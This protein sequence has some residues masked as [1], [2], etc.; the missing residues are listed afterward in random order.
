MSA[1]GIT[2]RL[3][4]LFRKAG[5]AAARADTAAVV[6]DEDLV[7]EQDVHY[8]YRLLLGREPDEEGLRAKRKFVGQPKLRGLV[9]SF[10]ESSEFIASELA[11][12]AKWRLVRKSDVDPSPPRRFFRADR[13]T[14]TDVYFAYR[15]LLQR[16]PDPEGWAGLASQAQR[17]AMPLDTLCKTFLSSPEFRRGSLYQELY[18]L[19][20]AGSP[21]LIELETHR[22][23]VMESDF[24]VGREL[25][26]GRP[27][28]PHIAATLTSFLSPGATFVDVGANIGVFSLM[29]A[30]IVGSGGRVIAIEPNPSNCR[31]IGM[32]AHENGFTNVEIIPGAVGDEPKTL[33]FASLVGSNG[34]VGDPVLTGPP[35]PGASLIRAETLNHLLAREPRVDFIKMD[36][37]GAEH[38]ALLGAREVIARHKPPI[39]LEFTPLGLPTVSGA[40]P[41][42]HL[43]FLGD[44]GYALARIGEGGELSPVTDHA[45]LVTEVVSQDAAQHADLLAYDP[46]SPPEQLR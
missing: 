11:V 29:A 9:E 14:R 31:L 35:G 16:E 38:R 33:V 17:K 24:A 1:P 20:Q 4:R 27:Y 26:D 10:L 32:G 41:E 34:I 15:L 36:I 28:E 2:G 18:G 3:K 25:L 5:P 42:T 46:N 45:A 8:C 7:T 44:L 19:D 30:S 6:R 13:A 43:Q 39:A 12:A 37:E 23:Y 21:R 22:Q 40:T